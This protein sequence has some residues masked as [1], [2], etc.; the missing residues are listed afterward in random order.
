[1]SWWTWGTLC[2]LSTRKPSALT[3]ILSWIRQNISIPSPRAS[4]IMTSGNR[5]YFCLIHRCVHTAWPIVTID[6]YWMHESRPPKVLFI[7]LYSSSVPLTLNVLSPSLYPLKGLSGL[8]MT[9]S[10]RNNNSFRSF[11]EHWLYVLP[12]ARRVTDI[13]SLNVHKIL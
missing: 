2:I 8:E 10:S 3:Q 1:M 7:N 9:P 12:G 4:S 13:T 11:I 6:I 5:D